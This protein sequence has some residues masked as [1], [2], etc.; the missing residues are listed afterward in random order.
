[1]IVRWVPAVNDPSLR[2]LTEKVKTYSAPGLEHTANLYV[3]FSLF[4]Q[5]II[6]K[7]PDLLLVGFAAN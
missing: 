5:Y 3:F 2:L 1:M 6:H 7:L 4:E